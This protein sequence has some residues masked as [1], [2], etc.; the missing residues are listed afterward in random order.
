M[1]CEYLVVAEKSNSD[2]DPLFFPFGCVHVSELLGPYL[3]FSQVFMIRLPEFSC[4]ILLDPKGIGINL[5]LAIYCIS[6][7]PNLWT[8]LSS[9]G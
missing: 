4:Y 9:K 7:P 3:E 5:F 2:S 8:H 6:L 1:S